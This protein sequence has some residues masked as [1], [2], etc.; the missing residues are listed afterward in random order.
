MTHILQH[1]NSDK[2]RE[3][4]TPLHI[5][6]AARNTMGSIDLDPAS[7]EFANTEVNACKIF[8]KADDGLHKNWYGNVWMNPP[9][10]KTGNRSNQDIWF[11]K[12]EHE[13]EHGLVVQA[14]SLYNV[15]VGS[16]WFN[17]LY[18]W[19]MCW[20]HE[21]IKFYNEHG[22]ATAPRYGNVVVYMGMDIK[23]FMDV[24]SE[25]GAVTQLCEYGGME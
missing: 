1:D 17:N 8:T 9:Y 7:C 15:S 25:Y 19:P 14:C 12:L 5:V 20:L 11:K 18:A 21:R 6:N 24:F 10:G 2:S 13:Y 4:Y 22:I 23:K 3:W 16:A